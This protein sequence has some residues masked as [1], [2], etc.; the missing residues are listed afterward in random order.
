MCECF[1]IGGKFIAEDPD[2]PIHGAEAQEREQE[3]ETRRTQIKNLA[4]EALKINRTQ[5]TNG[6]PWVSPTN[7]PGWMPPNKRAKLIAIL[8]QIEKLSQ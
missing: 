2:C 1:K 5:E 7:P 3:E 6:R 4:A 8:E